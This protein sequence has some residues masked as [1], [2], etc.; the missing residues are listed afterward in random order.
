M[1]I[2]LY[3]QYCVVC[4]GKIPLRHVHIH[5][6]HIQQRYKWKVISLVLLE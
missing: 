3:F 5:V 4:C 1:S 2:L 6:W